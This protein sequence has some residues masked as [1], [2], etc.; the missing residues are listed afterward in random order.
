MEEG[1]KAARK[2]TKKFKAVWGR[3]VRQLSSACEQSPLSHEA[4]GAD[5]HTMF[6]V[7]NGS[8]PS[9]VSPYHL[10]QWLCS[11]L[12]HGGV[13]AEEDE[14]RV[15][16]LF[17]TVNTSA[18]VTCDSRTYEVLSNA[19]MT[20]SMVL[21]CSINA[22]D[23]VEL[24]SSSVSQSAGLGA[25]VSPPVESSVFISGGSC[26]DTGRLDLYVYFPGG[27]G[28]S[29]FFERAL[30]IVSRAPVAGLENCREREVTVSHGVRQLIVMPVIQV[31]GVFVVPEFLSDKE[32]DDVLDELN[33]MADR[34]A[35]HS[36][37]SQRKRRQVKW[38][39]LARRDVA[40]FNRR[41]YYG[42]NRLGKE[43]DEDLGENIELPSFYVSI[44]NRLAMIDPSTSV[45]LDSLPWPVPSDFVCDQLTVNYYHGGKGKM[46]NAAR[47]EDGHHGGAPSGIPHHVDSHAS[48]DDF[49]FS[50]SLASHTVMELQR[51][52]AKM[53]SIGVFLPPRSL[54][55]LS[56]EGRYCWT[57]GISETRVDFLSDMLPPLERRNRLSL[58]WR[59]GRENVHRKD[60]CA[61]PA[62][63]DG[64]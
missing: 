53:P 54:L 2:R 29:T 10:R 17:S 44:R 62:L 19:I 56:G 25:I 24:A 33:V 23:D 5:G 59:K 31:P 41:F 8:P 43:G 18:V 60:Q 55:I 50:I 26:G 7:L 30:R 40:H 13:I 27:D 61:C 63:C 57:H 6:V 64:D 20:M 15:N 36:E 9:G 45:S 22:P 49:I 1:T 35:A 16:V 3:Y 46:C 42:A 52:D 21:R 34:S 14:N 39:S 28:T 51:W 48:L 12:A 38:E 4:K 32:H 37:E 47:E 11:L 58:T